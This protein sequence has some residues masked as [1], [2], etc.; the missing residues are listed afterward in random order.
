MD[1][2]DSL[3]RHSL[4]D[5]IGSPPTPCVSRE[6][7]QAPAVD[8]LTDDSFVELGAS[9]DELEALDNDAV[10]D[11]LMEPPMKPVS[12]RSSFSQRRNKFK[13]HKRPQKLNNCIHR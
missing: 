1:A 2:T 13:K 12:L 3:A 9:Q 11:K 5:D 10:S 7:S 8:V 6:T 4:Q